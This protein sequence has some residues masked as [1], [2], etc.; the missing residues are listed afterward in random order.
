MKEFKSDVK[1]RC[2]A[3]Y[4]VTIK[5]RKKKIST[6]KSLKTYQNANYKAT[7]MPHFNTDLPRH[8]THVQSMEVI[9]LVQ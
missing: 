7:I 8:T 9:Q 2:Y 5:W 3:Y 4:S 1:V 6:L